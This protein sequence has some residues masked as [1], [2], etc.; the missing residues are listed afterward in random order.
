[1]VVPISKEI[2]TELMSNYQPDNQDLFKAIFS[3]FISNSGNWRG[4]R[5]NEKHDYTLIET[6]YFHLDSS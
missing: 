3:R 2:P 5:G 1:M 4:N 6:K